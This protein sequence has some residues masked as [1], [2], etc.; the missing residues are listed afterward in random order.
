MGYKI[1]VDS[2]CE[3]TRELRADDRVESIP[4]GLEVG[5]YRI[6]D[7]ENFDQ[8]EF[9]SKVAE[10]SK[11]PKSYCPSPEAFKMAYHTK[12]EHVYCITLSSQLSGSYNSAVLAKQLYLD[13]YGEKKI[14][15]IDSQSASAGETQLV[16]KLME[17]EK[18]GFAFEQIVEKIEKYRDSVKT[19]FA[20]DNL[21]TLR[22]NGRLTGVKSL[23]ASTLNIKPVM[24]S[25][26]GVIYQKGQTIGMNKALR[27]MAEFVVEEVKSPDTRRLIITHCNAPKRADQLRKYISEKLDFKECMIL[28]TGGIS[29][30]YANN[31][32]IIV[33]A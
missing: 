29:S 33:T 25:D 4:L 28:D 7:D 15:V 14:H 12:A 30:M 23:V 17:W 21:E 27:K 11:C 26:H 19:Y 13:D 6:L 10:Y 3:L 20:L 18:A 24:G 5:D 8:K 16:L 32:G 1:V 2:C 9:L 31:G 22:K